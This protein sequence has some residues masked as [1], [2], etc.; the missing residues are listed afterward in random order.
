MR[1]CG[2][3]ARAIPIG[4][5]GCGSSQPSRRRNFLDQPEELPMP[6]AKFTAEDNYI[7]L[8]AENEVG[9][10]ETTRYF[11]SRSEKG[12][13]VKIHDKAGRFPQVCDKLYTTG[14]TLWATAD[15]L[16]D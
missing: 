14:P 6:R 10:V 16:A 1:K 2:Q 7:T 12:G 3:R 8:T 5:R 11:V 4:W 9:E 13:Y 15:T